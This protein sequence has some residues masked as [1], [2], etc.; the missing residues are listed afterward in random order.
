MEQTAFAL[1]N[2]MGGNI[3]AAIFAALLLTG[4]GFPFPGELTLGFTGYLLFTAQVNFLPAVIAT[5]AGDLLGALLGY[6]IGFF[7]RSQLVSRYLSFLTPSAGK[8]MAV[9][10][11][12]EKYGILAILCG[13][14][15][16]VVRG[17]VPIPAGFAAMDIKKYVVG[18]IFGS[19]IWCSVLIYLGFF[20]GHSWQQIA[21]FAS[22]FGLAA[23]G[24][25]GL[26]LLVWRLRRYKQNEAP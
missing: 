13:R 8:M 18:N 4:I 16:P 9:T 12:L 19:I 11:W 23:A 20:L 26:G 22:R 15:L 24:V 3:Y 21:G 2:T 10:G 25:L 17:A 14:L 7:S 1:A 6:G 5:A